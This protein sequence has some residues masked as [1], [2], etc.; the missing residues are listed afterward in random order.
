MPSNSLLRLLA[1]LMSLFLAAC[2]GGN[3]TSAPP[4]TSI[5]ESSQLR[6]VNT[7]PPTDTKLGLKQPI[8]VVLSFD[9]DETTIN[10]STVRLLAEAYDAS[11]PGSA[12]TGKVSY[13]PALKRINFLPVWSLNSNWHYTLTLNGIKDRSGEEMPAVELIFETYSNRAIRNISVSS[14][15]MYITTFEANGDYRTMLY[16]DAGP[17]G[18]WLTGDDV[19]AYYS[20][21]TSTETASNTLLKI[22][23]YVGAGTDGIWFTTDD[24]TSYCSATQTSLDKKGR[25][26]RKVEFS[27]PSQDCTNENAVSSYTT[28]EYDAQGHVKL[29]VNYWQ[30]GLDQ[31]WFTDDDPIFYYEALSENIGRNV[32][33][34]TLYKAGADAVWFTA[35]DELYAYTE[36]Y[37]DPDTSSFSTKR[38]IAPGPDQAWFTEDDLPS[39]QESGTF[40]V[41]DTMLAYKTFQLLGRG[42]DA[43]PGTADDD[44]YQYMTAVDIESGTVK[45]INFTGRGLDNILFTED[46]PVSDYTFQK[47]VVS[48]NG[49]ERRSIHTR[50]ASAGD[51]GLWFTSDDVAA[52][53]TAW[54]SIFNGHSQKSIH[55]IDAG[56]DV[57]WFTDDDIIGNYQ[58]NQYAENGNFILFLQVDGAGPDGVWFTD[59]DKI[60]YKTEYDP[61]N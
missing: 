27:G 16:N 36:I 3:S 50:Y 19:L 10:A 23:G 8:S 45:Y 14:G 15:S 60:L 53:V 13:D 9:A 4:S 29:T 12:V 5:P 42:N 49:Q 43:L 51:D 54:L 40:N 52:E 28:Y 39:Y 35:D 20:Y 38:Y 47:N 44:I 58:I 1:L 30:P 11:T 57:T 33:Y 55:Y 18:Q 26:I 22:V 37:D 48:S 2:G 31:K 34:F 7:Q 61:L 32:K 46:D 6:V 41:D 25:Q 59:D 56:A 17:D 21:T 24:V